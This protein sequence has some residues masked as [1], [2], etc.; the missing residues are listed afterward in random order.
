MGVV[1]DIKNRY[2]LSRNPAPKLKRLF[3]NSPPAREVAES[4]CMDGVLRECKGVLIVV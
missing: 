4:P 1:K 2:S 3:A